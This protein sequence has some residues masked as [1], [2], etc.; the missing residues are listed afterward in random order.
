METHVKACGNELLNTPSEAVNQQ[1][2]FCIDTATHT[3][4]CTHVQCMQMNGRRCD[5]RYH[6]HNGTWVSW[7]MLVRFFD[8]FLFFSA[9]D[10]RVKRFPSPASLHQRLQLQL[11]L[12]LQLGTAFVY[13]TYA[14]D[15]GYLY[16]TF[17]SIPNIFVFSFFSLIC[18]LLPLPLLLL[19]IEQS[20]V[21]YLLMMLWP[22]LF[23]ELGQK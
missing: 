16:I 19:F 20:Q 12:Q 2:Q 3:Y 23:Y 6:S 22:H 4:T 5:A 7:K 10:R 1:L 21:E 8:G 18:L 9:R 17:V 15:L 11:Q 14:I 13:N